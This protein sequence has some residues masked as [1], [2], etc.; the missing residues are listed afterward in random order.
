M[1]GEV[2]VE[3]DVVAADHCWDLRLV[4]HLLQRAAKARAPGAVR[5][6]RPRLR[7]LVEGGDARGGGHRIAV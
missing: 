1:I 5:L 4:Q 3:H 2:D 7:D 6:I